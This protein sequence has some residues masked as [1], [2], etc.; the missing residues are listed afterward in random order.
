MEGSASRAL[1]PNQASLRSMCRVGQNHI[2]II[3]TVYIWYFWLGNHQI[4][5]VYLR[6]YT[7]LA[8][9]KHVSAGLECLRLAWQAMHSLVLTDSRW[10]RP[11]PPPSAPT[12]P[13]ALMRPQPAAMREPRAMSS[14]RDHTYTHA[15]MHTHIHIH[16]RINAYTH[17]HAHT[18]TYIHTCIH[19]HTHT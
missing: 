10:K 2:Y 4:Y 12:L 5:G 11:A 17:I 8:N 18:H 9:A 16:K 15:Y 6:I 13:L 1:P 19:K 14:A 7:V 3:Y